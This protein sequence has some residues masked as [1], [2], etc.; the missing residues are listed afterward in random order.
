MSI[1]CFVLDFF[2]AEIFFSFFLFWLVPQSSLSPVSG[3]WPFQQCWAGVHL[4]EWTLVRIRSTHDQLLSH[5]CASV[6]QRALQA[7]V[8][9]AAS[10]V[11]AASGVKA[12]GGHQLDLHV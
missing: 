2:F 10:T 6:V 7:G 12:L 4:M 3:S 8:Q 5:F 1:C 9:S 11:S